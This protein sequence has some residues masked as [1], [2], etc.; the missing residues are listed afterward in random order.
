MSEFKLNKGQQLA[1]DKIVS[2]RNLIVCG[3]GGVGKSVLIHKLKEDFSSDTIFMSTTGISAVAIGGSTFHSG[4]S[5]PVGHVTKEA[6]KRVSSDVQ[7]LFSKGV[8]KR[9]VVDEASMITPSTWHGFVQRLLRFS[10][11]TK[12]RQGGGF[13][14]ILFMD[15]LQ[16]GAVMQPVD[17]KLAREEYG[18]DKF[19]RMESF[20]DMDFD[21]VELTEVMRQTDIEM[22]M[23]LSRIREAVPVSY[24]GKVPVFDDEVM[25]AI[26]YFNKRVIYP[27]PKNTPVLA[28]TNKAVAGY[29]KVAY[30]QNYNG[31]GLYEA[32]FTGDYKVA[33]LP[34]DEKL[35]LKEGL[36]VIIVKNSPRESTVKYVN[37]DRATVVSMSAEGVMVKLK[38]SGISVLIEPTRWEKHGYSTQTNEDG[39]EELV[40]YVSGSA[41]QVALKQAASLSIHRSQGSSLDKAIIDLGWS[42]G[43]SHGLTYVALSRLRSIDGLYLKRKIRPDDISVDMEALSW[44]NEMRNKSLQG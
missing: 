12:N 13:Q 11:K 33:D 28:S 43:W 26:D 37:G 2:G 3:E 7:K 42:G 19:F 30:D 5:I 18:T 25:E 29:N 23:M 20:N 21:F 24:N 32:A 1:Y 34:C 10:K 38:S 35:Y 6:L 27:L 44:L 39:V 31:A 36:D 22:K 8:I 17:I 9:I 40:Q 15:I 16:L 41:T 4:M 14:V